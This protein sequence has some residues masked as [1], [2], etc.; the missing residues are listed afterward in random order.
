MFCTHLHLAFVH[1]Q[2]EKIPV[3]YILKRYTK[4]AKSDMPFD[5]RDRDST[6]PDGVE[7]NYRSNMMIIEAFGV[8]K[9]ACKSKVAYD[10]A[11]A[12]LKGLRSQSRT[13]QVTLQSPKSHTKG[14]M[15]VPD[16]E[17]TLGAKGKK[18]CTRECGWCHL[19]DGHY[20]N[21]CPKNP[22]N[23]DKIRKVANRERGKRGRPRGS[24]R[25]RGCGVTTCGAAR[26]NGARITRRNGGSDHT[27]RRCLEDEWESM[28]N[29]ARNDELDKTDGDD[30]DPDETFGWEK[31]ELY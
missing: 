10:I 17:V 19:R 1:V 31:N 2:L 5:R 25:G 6:S 26:G 30:V 7:E 21:T 4:K 29:D 3:A 24:G 20:A 12:V 13:Y 18:L 9:A 8:V 27:L 11:M 15:G 22:V 14:S 16:E 28:G 23:F